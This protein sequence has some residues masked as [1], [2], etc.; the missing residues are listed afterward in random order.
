MIEMNI[1]LCK[2]LGLP[3]QATRATL[4]IQAGSLPTLDVNL[5]CLDT[6]G[7][8]IV[9]KGAGSLDARL[10]AVDF[11]FVLI[12]AESLGEKPKFEAFQQSLLALCRLHKVLLAPSMYDSFQAWDLTDGEE[13][14]A[15]D[16]EDRT[17]PAKSDKSAC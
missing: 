3:S 11:R 16:L 10:A 15:V 9:D 5:L 1:K 14:L 13:P 2:A 8:W 6:E 17:R 12:A 4:T 7:D